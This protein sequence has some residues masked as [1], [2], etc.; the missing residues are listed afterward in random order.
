MDVRNDQVDIGRRRKVAS[1]RVR[2]GGCLLC[3][4]HVRIHDDDDERSARDN[5]PRE[6]VMRATRGEQANNSRGEGES[7]HTLVDRMCNATNT[8]IHEHPHPHQSSLY[9]NYYLILSCIR[10]IMNNY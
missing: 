3:R 4:D 7:S 9:D 5:T 8:S 6:R 2:D 1:H 10:R